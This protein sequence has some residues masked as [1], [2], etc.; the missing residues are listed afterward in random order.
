MSLP[1]H[2]ALVFAVF[3]TTFLFAQDTTLQRF[4][5]MKDDTIKIKALTDYAITFYESDPA[6]SLSIFEQVVAV[7]QKID[8]PYSIGQAWIDI[9][10]M[11]GQMA[12][13][14]VAVES[15]K[16]AIPFFK[17]INRVDKVAACLLNIGACAERF[18]DMNGRIHST[19]EAVNLLEKTNH[20]SLLA[21][22]YNSL[23]ITFYNQDNFVQAKPYFEKG[24]LVG[25]QA[26]DTLKQVMALY[27]L[28]NCAIGMKNFPVALAHSLD[29]LA[30][31]KATGK[32][33]VLLLAYTSLSEVAIKMKSAEKAISYTGELMSYAE[34]TKDT[35]YQLLGMMNMAEAY[36]LKGD[37][38]KRIAYLRQ[39]LPI[40]EQNGVVIQL[41]DIYKSLSE[42]YEIKGDHKAALATFRKH[43]FYRDSTIN[44]KSNKAI[45]EIEI[46]YQT[47]QKEKALSDKQV[48]IIQK[49]LQL[50]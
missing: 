39:A 33:G 24:R 18:G 23:G 11:Q 4:Q 31:A 10:S 21:H 27:G 37:Q 34:K 1:K 29:A 19:M 43:I 30:L 46:K 44:L 42:A 2:A 22:G 32:N 16:K 28:S 20:K 17:K 47:A 9:G 5:A 26:K 45:A 12:R 48:Q 49:D 25:Q 13:D 36:A 35:H 40:A 3:L 38:Q 6:K 50:Q 14:Q 41:D 15:F 7:G 8:H